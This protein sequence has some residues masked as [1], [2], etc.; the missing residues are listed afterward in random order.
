M[1]DQAAVEVLYAEDNPNDAELTLRALKTSGIGNR[2]EIARDG[3]EALAFLHGP[4]GGRPGLRLILLDLKLPRVSGLEVLRRIR[5]D[6]R[7]RMIPVVIL[8]S[9]R[10]PRDVAEAY[11]LGANSYTVKPVDYEKFV[12]A[13]G[14]I[15]HYWLQFNESPRT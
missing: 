4:E 8:T 2:V 11:R 1:T 13:V 7:T 15:G 5:E 9:S 12:A 14:R 3:V 10:E 6:V